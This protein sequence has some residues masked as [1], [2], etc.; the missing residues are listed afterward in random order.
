MP[1]PTILPLPCELAIPAAELLLGPPPFGH[2]LRCFQEPAI[3]QVPQALVYVVSVPAT[4]LLQTIHFRDSPGAAADDVEVTTTHWRW[5][6][7]GDPGAADFAAIE[8]RNDAFWTA[9]AAHRS[10]VI[11]GGEYRWYPAVT[12]G[13]PGQALRVTPSSAIAGVTNNTLP[14]QVA[15]TITQITDVRRRWGRFYVGGL[16][17]GDNSGFGRM[18]SAAVAAL[19]DAGEDLFRS[20]AT[21]DWEPQVFGAPEPNSLPIRAIRV[22]DVYDVIRSR[23][24]GAPLIRETRDVTGGP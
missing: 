8:A 20:G 3:G 11:T 19:A 17:P 22:D 1:Y 4:Y 2:A 6:G 15:Q 23:R 21:P 9:I 12:S 24:Y 14:P 5:S 10:D 18:T 7:S 16:I 13:Q